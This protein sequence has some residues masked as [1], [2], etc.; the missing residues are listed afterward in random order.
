MPAALEKIPISSPEN[1]ER[2]LLDPELFLRAIPNASLLSER[3]LLVRVSFRLFLF[4][5]ADEYRVTFYTEK[6]GYSYEFRGK[7]STLRFLL[8]PEGR[9]LIIK[10]TYEGRFKRLVGLEF[11]KFAERLARNL[12]K[13]IEELPE[14]SRERK[15]EGLFEVNFED[16][17]DFKRKLYCFLLLRTEEFFVSQ[18][19]LEQLLPHLTQGEKGIFYISG[20]SPD[21]KKR[22]QVV[23][24]EGKVTSVRYVEDGRLRIA[25]LSLN[26][27][28]IDRILRDIAG[29]F[30]V[31]VWKKIGRVGG[32]D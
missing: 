16:P 30:V 28:E 17:T 15:E 9:E 12:E 19:T 10:T 2:V 25:R 3:R 22:F 29:D 11:R 32:G 27:R 20:I 8:R 26:P 5:T 31:N 14:V 13:L 24:Q 1:L 7:K 6:G 4:S 18:N 21:G 23:S